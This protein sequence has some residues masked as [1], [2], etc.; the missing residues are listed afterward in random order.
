MRGH[1]IASFLRSRVGR[2]YIVFILI[3]AAIAA[4]VGFR[5]FR[6]SVVAFVAG[7]YHAAPF[8]LVRRSLWAC[9]FRQNLGT[10]ALGNWG[11]CRGKG[12]RHPRL[13]G[14]SI[15]GAA[16]KFGRV[17]LSKRMWRDPPGRRAS[18]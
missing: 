11:A 4:G 18:S 16:A 1:N 5:S 7:A 15:A 3:S 13:G 10:Q 17:R 12:D 14:Q 6:T 8:S 9:K 2:A